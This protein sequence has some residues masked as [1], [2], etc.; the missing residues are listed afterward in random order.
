MKKRKSKKRKE[1]NKMMCQKVG[2]NP[3]SLPLSMVVLYRANFAQMRSKYEL[4]VNLDDT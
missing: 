2:S 3:L 1:R 4:T